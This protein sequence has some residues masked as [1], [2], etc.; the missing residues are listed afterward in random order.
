MNCTESVIGAVKL[1]K[2]QK[3]DYRDV[4]RWEL[5]LVRVGHALWEQWKRDRGAKWGAVGERGPLWAAIQNVWR[6]K[7]D[8]RAELAIH[9]RA[10]FEARRHSFAGRYAVDTPSCRSIPEVAVQSVQLS[11]PY[12]C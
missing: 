11:N 6:L 3:Y 9:R 4:D 1:S 7:K 2:R 12:P 8:Y 5:K 10:E